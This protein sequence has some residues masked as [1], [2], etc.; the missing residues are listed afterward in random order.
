M[1]KVPI[2]AKR[3]KGP[4]TPNFDK[5]D[6]LLEIGTGASIVF[7][8][9]RVIDQH[10]GIGVK[11][12]FVCDLLENIERLKKHEARAFY[13][14]MDLYINVDVFFSLIENIDVYVFELYSILDYFAVELSEIFE[15]KVER[16]GKEEQVEYFT[17]LID[18]KNLQASI[19][20]MVKTLVSQPWFDYF[21]RL[22]NRVTHRTLVDLPGL[23][24]YENGKI[25]D[26]QYPFLPDN[27]DEVSLT[28]SKK[29][30]VVGESKKWLEGIFSF[31]N[32]VCGILLSLF[33]APAP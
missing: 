3:T 25:V 24:R 16:K 31:V 5:V 4:S 26:F 2:R 23:A 32:D 19:K 33:E 22:R 1:R 20:A 21:H 18:A 28:C 10:G 15:L 6:H 7:P 27:P 11:M 13:Q 30:D 8:H 17:G 9:D 12:S 29:Y 14:G